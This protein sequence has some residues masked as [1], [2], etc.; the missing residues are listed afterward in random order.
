MK[1]LA[2]AAGVGVM[3]AGGAMAFDACPNGS[4]ATAVTDNGTTY[5]LLFD[6]FEVYGGQIGKCDIAVPLVGVPKGTIGVYTADYRGFMHL[7]D[8]ADSSGA[9]RIENNGTE[10]FEEFVAP[11]DVDLEYTRIVASDGDAVVRSSA[12][13]DMRNAKDLIN[14]RG[15][16]DSLEYNEIG[17][18]TL[19]TDQMSVVTHIGASSEL[20]T[21][22]NQKLEGVNE[23]GVFG[24]IGSAMLG[25]N[26]RYNL[27]DGLSVLGGVAYIS[28]D[29]STSDAA[30]VVGAAAVRYVQPGDAAF[31]PFVEGG[32]TLAGLQLNFHDTPGGDDSTGAVLGAVHITG[33]VET[34]IDD[35]NTVILSASV[36]ESMLGVAGYMLTDGGDF[37]ATMPDQAGYFTKFSASAAWHSQITSEID[38][39]ATGTIGAIVPHGQVTAAVDGLGEV[40]ATAPT[41]LFAE[42]GLRAGWDIA[43]GSRVEGFVQGSVSAD[44]GTHAQI[45]AAYKLQF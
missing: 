5:S 28:Q 24:G 37:T 11:N 3:G 40:T 34:A 32:V 13:I 23:F 31:R 26:G 35:A 6:A 12:T 2:I 19:G 25:V 43:P 14:D 21:G 38:V 27:G 1:R 44:Y 29:Y 39:Q 20:L 17:R 30:G 22:A 45:G 36:R 18:I 41:S 16:F 15:F 33:G 8:E 10:V 7:E 9:V 42:Y 4:I